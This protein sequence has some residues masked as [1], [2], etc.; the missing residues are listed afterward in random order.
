VTQKVSVSLWSPIVTETSRGD[1]RDS[2]PPGR[3]RRAFAG[4]LGHTRELGLGAQRAGGLELRGVGDVLAIRRKVLRVHEDSGR[5]L[6]ERLLAQRPADRHDRDEDEREEDEP[7]AAPENPQGVPQSRR[8]LV[9]ASVI[10]IRARE[11]R[12]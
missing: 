10:A 5:G 3:A 9:N 12:P 11:T 6:V 7:F 4:D 2:S 1:P 8:P